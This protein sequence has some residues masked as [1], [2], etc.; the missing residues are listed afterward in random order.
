[1]EGGTSAKEQVD[2]TVATPLLVLVMR[3]SDV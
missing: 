2:A 1:M 3:L